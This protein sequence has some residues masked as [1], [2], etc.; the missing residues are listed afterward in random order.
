MMML[1]STPRGAYAVLLDTIRALPQTA[2][3][4]PTD[5]SSSGD[6][7]EET[8]PEPTTGLMPSFEGIPN[9]AEA[10]AAHPAPLVE[11]EEAERL[12]SR[13]DQLTRR[14]GR[15]LRQH[16]ARGTMI[17][18]VFL[19]ALSGLGFVRGFVLAHFLT[20]ADYG[21]WGILAVSLGTLLWLKQV[22]IGDKYIQQDEAD[23]ELAFQKAFTL[24]L[25]FN[26]IFMV[27]LAV[28]LPVFALVYHQWQLVPPGLVILAV[29]PAGALQAPFWVYYRNMDFVRQRTLQAIDP[30]VGF[31]V[32]II[33]AYAGAG[34]WALAAGVLAGAWSSAIAAV[35]VSPYRLRLRYDRGTL[36]SYA[37]FSWPLFIAN[38]SSLVI[39]QSAVIASNAKLG[40][41]G[42]GV[43]ALA[44]NI[45]TFTNR[46]DGLV[47]GTLYPAICAVRDKLPLLMESFV[48]SNRLALMWAMPFGIALSLF[49][50]DLVH[51]GL[52]EKWRPAVTLLQVYG[53]NAAFSH[54][55][56][57][58]DAYMRATSRTRPL[59]V[60]SAA[61]MITFLVAGLPL[62]FAYGLSGLAAG[63][64]LQTVAH[65]VARAYYLRQ[66]F[67]GFA[68]LKHALRSVLPTVP[69]V[70]VVLLMRAVESSERTVWVALGELTAYFVVTVAATWWSERDLLREAVGYVVA[71]R[72]RA[73]AA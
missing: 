33:F 12:E 37:S 27:I 2:A 60:A 36:R 59:A 70:A 26:A 41:A 57:N 46:V 47:T 23:Q 35:I 14:H 71:R 51:F 31:V 62:L 42:V 58:W 6:D 18:T 21:V 10:F 39:A 22:G 56:F 32:A 54:I 73:A 68:F 65:M 15:G 13:R 25:S 63:V 49:C 67:H 1:A 50:S 61:A 45:T 64:V 3:S 8:L 17:N 4:M 53:I 29:L 40:L 69:A 38:G 30:V 28:L 24:E 20:R 43:I 44:S 5:S 7:R 52:G 55:A 66:L 48:K 11:P 72:A 16:A 9:D 19:I 34:Y